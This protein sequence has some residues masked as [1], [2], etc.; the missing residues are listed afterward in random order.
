MKR[1]LYAVLLIAASLSPA[2]A[3]PPDDGTL[4]AL[5]EAR[6]IR[7][8]VEQT[9][10]YNTRENAERKIMAGFRLP[11]AGLA[12]ALLEG[13]GIRVIEPLKGEAGDYGASLEIV[14][15]GRA[16]ARLYDNQAEG[17]L[18][19]GAEIVGNIALSAPGV[20]PWHKAFRSVQGPP[21]TVQFNL[22]FDRPQGAPFAEAFSGP[23]SFTAR[24]MEVIGRLYGARPLIAALDSDT[25]AVRLHA[26]KVLG[27]VG[28]D[29]ATLALLALIGDKEPSLRK[30]AAWSLGRLGDKRAVDALTRALEDS[31]PDVRWFAAWSLAKIFKK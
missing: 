4:A 21:L 7:L 12:R 13:A 5:R 16:I 15:H 19:S 3:E 6:I 2:S 11:Y 1:P 24:I 17:Y 9:Y 18:Y 26:A 30:E 20:A 14:A 22:G 31:N 10:L 25:V 29:G 8:T 23:T 28:G 27:T